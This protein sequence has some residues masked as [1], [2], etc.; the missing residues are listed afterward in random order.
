MAEAIAPTHSDADGRAPAESLARQAALLADDALMTSVAD[1]AQTYIAILNQQRQIVF[2]NRTLLEAFDHD[3]GQA[4]GKRM[5][6]LLECQNANTN[7][8]GCGSTPFCTACG[9]DTS[10]R[11]SRTG[12]AQEQEC[13][14]TRKDGDPIE[15]RVSATSFDIQGEDFILF[16][17]VDVGDTKR[18]ETL[19]RIFFH[20]IMNTATGMRGLSAMAKTAPAEDK[21]EMLELLEATSDH[22]IDEISAQRE[23]L[24]AESDELVARPQSVNSRQWLLD[25]AGIYSSHDVGTGKVITIAADS[26]EITFISD[27][28]LLGRVVGN[29][30]KNA[31]EATA[32]GGVVAIACSKLGS[33]IGFSVHN[34]GKIPHRNQLQ[35]FQRS[36]TTKGVGRGLGTYGS[37]LL[38]ERYL[39]GDIA[40][41]S[42]DEDGTT[43]TVSYPCV[44][45]E[46]SSE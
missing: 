44:P 43:F 24:A 11:A 30:V 15:L 46:D 1:S 4:T 32:P 21:D 14:I 7:T 45:V 39:G 17:G 12:G 9:A 36:F 2:A 23:L 38:T 40:F 41:E 22:L 35:I 28:V 16:T 19:E 29:L 31:L 5:G 20:D 8:A 13:R 26:D 33:R 42:N 6:D 3:T 10:I 34:S 27:P 25:I 18:R 37:R